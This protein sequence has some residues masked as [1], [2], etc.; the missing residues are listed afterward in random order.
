MPMPELAREMTRAEFMNQER[1][2]FMLDPLTK[3]ML[4]VLA[5]QH[6]PRN[7]SR[8]VRDAIKL[9]YDRYQRT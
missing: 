4:G 3:R 2:A 7:E 5:D 9:A 6:T 1:K 8:A